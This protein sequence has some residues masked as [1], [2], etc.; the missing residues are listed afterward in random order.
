MIKHII[1]LPKGCILH[2]FDIIGSTNVEARKL[3][4]GGAAAWSVVWAKTQTN[5]RGRAGKD[6]YSPVGNLYMS[7][8]LR[9]EAVTENLP[10]LSF[11]TAVAVQKALDFLRYPVTFKW[12]NDI[13]LN[14]K[15]VAGILLESG[16]TDSKRWLVIGLGINVK[17]FPK[18]A[19][20]PATSICA[21]DEEIKV[22][23]EQMLEEVIKSL[24]KEIDTWER[25]GFAS[26]R[27]AWL[28]SA[29]GIGRPINMK[30]P[31][32]IAAGIFDSLDESGNLLLK[33]EGRV[34]KISA[35]ELFFDDI[36]AANATGN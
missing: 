18:D 19:D 26:V 27:K 28:K 35:G 1:D 23:P 8:I 16:M 2:R 33:V 15:K 12:P 11:V 17:E 7:V 14:G 24:A 3:A 6:W 31:G 29:V 25:E 4:E 34:R 21:E 20:Y 9:P 5:G 32:E 13:L 30:L 22:S 10:Q 36:G